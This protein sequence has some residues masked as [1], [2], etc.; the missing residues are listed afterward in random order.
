LSKTSQEHEEKALKQVRFG[1]LT[2]STSR[3]DKKK[4]GAPFTDASAEVAERILTASGHKVV[5]RKVVSDDSEMIQEGICQMVSVCE[6]DAV[7]GMG[8][9]GI[10]PTDVTVETVA[11][12]FEKELQGFGEAFRRIS[13]DEIGG[14]AIVSRC[15]AGIMRGKVV[16]CLPG[17]PQAVETALEK[18]IV[19]EVGHILVHARAQD[20]R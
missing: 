3:Y 9:T 6:V 18:L 4:R 19:P 10:T 8:G 11:P 2:I 13:Y 20:S 7:L 12:L 1:L 16:F 15:I 17:S 5:I 14:A